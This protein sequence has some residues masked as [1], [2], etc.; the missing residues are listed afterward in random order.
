M[1]AYMIV[2]AKIHNREKFMKEYALPTSELLSKYGGEYVV[3]APGVESLEGGLF[4]GT[5]VVIS[6]WQSKSQIKKFWN[7][8]EYRLLKAARHQSAEAY[9]MIVEE[10]K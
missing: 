4:D 6:K 7:S 8:P 9:V 3:R 10:P 5:S 1:A 2:F